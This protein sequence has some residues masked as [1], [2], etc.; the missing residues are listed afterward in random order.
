[1][2]ASVTL[3][4]PQWYGAQFG[5]EG[6]GREMHGGFMDNS[7]PTLAL[8]QPYNW[9]LIAPSYSNAQT[10]LS[11]ELHIDYGE[12]PFWRIR[13]RLSD[14]KPLFDRNFVRMCTTFFVS[15]HSVVV[16]VLAIFAGY[17]ADSASFSDN[18]RYM[19]V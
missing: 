8:V 19:Y 5:G 17:C 12:V 2:L 1:M 10:S 6:L 18:Y 14:D 13:D 15:M 7:Y 3:I 4:A 11:D 9:D 16:V